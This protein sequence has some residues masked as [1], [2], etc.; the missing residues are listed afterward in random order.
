MSGDVELET[1]TAPLLDEQHAHV[2]PDSARRPATSESPTDADKDECDEG[3]SH[4]P[5][6]VDV[7][8]GTHPVLA[9]IFNVI[10]R[11][12]GWPSKLHRK[13]WQRRW[14][15]ACVDAHDGLSPAAADRVF[16]LCI[17]LLSQQLP[18][19]SDGEHSPHLKPAALKFTCGCGCTP[20]SKQPLEGA[21]SPRDE[22]HCDTAYV[23]E[24]GLADNTVVFPPEHSPFPTPLASTLAGL[25][26][27]AEAL[28]AA[29]ERW[30]PMVQFIDPSL[31][32]FVDGV[33]SAPS[34]HAGHVFRWVAT[35]FAQSHEG[36]LSVH[37]G[38]H[39]LGANGDRLWEATLTRLVQD[40][41]PA[42]QRVLSLP[43]ATA[44]G[45]GRVTV[46][47][48]AKRILSV[49]VR[50]ATLS[51][52]PEVPE[53]PASAFRIDGV[54]ED[55]IVATAYYSVPVPDPAPAAELRFRAH[56]DPSSVADRDWLRLH[57]GDAYCDACGAT[58]LGATQLTPGSL[59]VYP[60]T[61][62]HALARLVLPPGASSAHHRFVKVCL[63][64]N[65]R[66]AE[67]VPTM[68]TVPDETLGGDVTLEEQRL[69]RELLHLER[70]WL[71]ARHD[72]LKHL[73]CSHH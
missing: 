41:L 47:L 12:A 67:E 64:V 6:H 13:S 52:R 25:F 15:D 28:S 58:V 11:T 3:T 23:R 44:A 49:I 4:S 22:C 65:A 7:P 62:E 43:A 60:N 34:S 17:R 42:F 59:V 30:E 57:F 46:D 2:Q 45:E 53:I 33:H 21:S 18:S 71:R 66:G 70:Y 5:L 51:V 73:N 55:R 68:N 9:T 32:C 29:T 50:A 38:I 26:A 54:P 10:Q 72:A 48:R 39:G 14:R 61:I 63:V 35:E 37:G 69:H 31:G 56:V 24:A 8:D 40:I 16:A 19:S 20:C 27:E 36:A 1:I